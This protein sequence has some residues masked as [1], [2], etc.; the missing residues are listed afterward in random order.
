MSFIFRTALKLYFSNISSVLGFGLLL[1]FVLFF[2]GMQGVFTSSGS[3]FFTYAVPAAGYLE[4]LIFGLVFLGF[5]FAYSVFTITVV[6]AVRS[7]LSRVKLHY[8]FSEKIRRFAVKYFVFLALF[9]LA[10]FFLSVL[11][12]FAGFKALG[13]LLSAAVVFFLM[14]LPQAIVVDEESMQSSLQNAFEFSLKHK[15]TTFLVFLSALL[16]VFALSVL[17]FALNVFLLP[18]EFLSLLVVSFFLVPFIE[19]VKT[20]YYMEKMGLVKN[21]SLKLQ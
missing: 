14:F 16:A 13:F 21:V 6:F 17:E 19:V 11:L 3:I 12:G 18:G 8:Y 20:I 9:S 7:Q 10:S 5:I 2:L 4:S 1:V 15:K